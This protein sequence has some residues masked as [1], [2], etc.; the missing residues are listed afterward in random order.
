MPLPTP[1]RTARSVHA[2]VDEALVEMLYARNHS[3]VG[4]GVLFGAVLVWYAWGKAPAWQ[5]LGWLALKA[6]SFV[7]RDQLCRAFARRDRSAPVDVW[8]RRLN[9]ALAYDGIIWGLPGMRFVDREQL[10]LAAVIIGSTVGVAAMGSVLLTESL[11]ANLAFNGVLLLPLAARHLLRH[12]DANFAAGVGTIALCALLLEHGWRASKAT[13]ETLRLRYEIDDAREEA[14]SATR[15]KSAFLAAM[16]H[17]LRTPLNAVVGLS[18]LLAEEDL[19]G[20]LRAKVEGIQTSA[21]SL[22]ALIGQILDFSKIEHG[23]VELSPEPSSLRDLLSSAL[24][25]VEVGA[26][27]R[28]LGLV[29]EIDP[30]CPA[31][32]LVDS[33]RLK[34]VL[35]NLLANAVKFTER[36]TVGISAEPCTLPGGGEGLSFG[37]K[38]TGIGIA[39]EA[40]GRLF[41]PFTQVDASTSRLY[42]GSGLGLAIA[43]QLC[44]AMGGTLTAESTPGQGS[45]FRFTVAAR[46]AQPPALV[47]RT[48]RAE[49][50]G[51]RVLVVDDNELNRMV[52]KE[53]LVRLGCHPLVAAGGEQAV[54]LWEQERPPVV[55][56]DVQMPRMDGL[57]ATRLLRER[58]G[59][60]L[61]PWVMALTASAL[62]EDEL[63]CREAGMNDYLAKPIPLEALRG[64]LSR[65]VQ[66]T[67]A[68]LAPEETIAADAPFARVGRVKSNPVLESAPPVAQ[69]LFIAHPPKPQRPLPDGDIPA[70][71]E[72]VLELATLQ[73]IFG[74]CVDDDP[75]LLRELLHSFEASGRKNLELLRQAV[76]IG[77]A[78]QLRAAAHSLRGSAAMLGGARVREAC[79]RLEEA[80]I[81]GQTDCAAM[82]DRVEREV[83]VFAGA[84]TQLLP[85]PN[86]AA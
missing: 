26:R 56:M 41:Q 50:R 11:R 55:L 60:P 40:L 33:T 32:V 83:T 51:L 13:R 80:A 76:E 79:A 1:P 8:R 28:G 78:P 34:Q 86:P 58:S 72:P 74:G 6:S 30:R 9:L 85:P 52:A 17:E 22:L 18:S 23:K 62:R 36:G 20:P 29:E 12:T 71:A 4:V 70:G 2:R 35:V 81:A 57:A 45:C 66:A 43:R 38:D 19:S 39:P 77:N 48:A 25:V 16:S 54:A 59:D 15:A 84:L 63:R 21:A 27:Q 5:L 65:A 53:M 75:L 37:V 7:L 73:A 69:P 68:A 10:E 46:P 24:A 64:A 49:V 3:A 67:G 44:E 14:L 42:G 47:Q 61:R 31:W 82:I